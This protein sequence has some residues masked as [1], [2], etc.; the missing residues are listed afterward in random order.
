RT[1]L[2]QDQLG[3]GGLAA[4]G[5]A[6]HPQGLTGADRERDAVD[7]LDPGALA[8]AEQPTADR[9]VLLDR[10]QLNDR[11]G[12]AGLPPSPGNASTWRPTP[13]Q[14]GCLPAPLRC[15]VAARERSAAGRRSPVAAWR[16]WAA[17]R[18]SRTAAPCC[19]AWRSSRAAPRC[20]DG[21]RC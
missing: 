3:G 11:R 13:D 18:G 10:V 9:V 15:S 16:G 2:Q 17:G 12:H 5:F 6:D 8:R 21:A 14:N 20:R 19:R 1:D 7:R 4:A